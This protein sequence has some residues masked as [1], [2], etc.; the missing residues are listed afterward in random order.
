MRGKA[1]CYFTL[2]DCIV[3]AIPKYMYVLVVPWLWWVF[4]NRS[5]RGCSRGQYKVYV[6][7][8]L[9]DRTAEAILQF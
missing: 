8:P 5:I 4:G 2:P 6:L 9:Y 3:S 7:F 1:K